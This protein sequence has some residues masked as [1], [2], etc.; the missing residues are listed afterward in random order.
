MKK[1]ANGTIEKLKDIKAGEFICKDTKSK[2]FSRCI[3]LVTNE[4]TETARKIVNLA[5]GKT[6]YC[7]E[8]EEVEHIYTI[9]TVTSKEEAERLPE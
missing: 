1:I 6:I 5:T 2:Y 3:F 4:K 7:N 8:N 9:L